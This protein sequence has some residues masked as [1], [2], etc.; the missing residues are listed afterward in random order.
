MTYCGDT[1]SP[2]WQKRHVAFAKGRPSSSDDDSLER[3]AGVDK[4][5][6][7]PQLTWG[8]EGTKWDGSDWSRVE[9][10]EEELQCSLLLEPHLQELLGGEDLFLAGTGVEDGLLHTLMPDNPIPSTMENAEW[11]P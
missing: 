5:Y 10:G 9:G 11:I 2:S 1:Q 7:M 4:V 3:D 8:N 6:Q